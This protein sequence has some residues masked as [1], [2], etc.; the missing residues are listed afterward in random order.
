MKLAKLFA[1]F[2]DVCIDESG[3]ST[4]FSNIIMVIFAVA[5]TGIVMG[6]IYTALKVFAA[7]TG[8]DIQ[9]LSM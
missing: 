5:G 4:I 7:S 2:K 9:N 1:G 3:G 8:Q 6:I